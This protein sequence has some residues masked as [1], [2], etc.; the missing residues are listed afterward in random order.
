MSP[1]A[2]KGL[3]Q[4][5][6]PLAPKPVEVRKP[7]AQPPKAAGDA[8]PEPAPKKILGY[9][10]LTWAKIIPLGAMFFCILFNYTIL[11]DTKVRR[12]VIASDCS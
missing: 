7:L 9:E 1:A 2:P 3:T 12:L 8:T 5:T 6:R 11:R 4:M 10:P